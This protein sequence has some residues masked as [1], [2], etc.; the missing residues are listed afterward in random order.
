M[1]DAYKDACSHKFVYGVVSALVFDYWEPKVVSS[2]LALIDSFSI[3]L[4]A[5]TW[6]NRLLET[7]GCQS[8][9]TVFIHFLIYREQGGI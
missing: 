8:G 5:F 4:L 9:P 3:N 1:L 6:T 7:Q 2:I